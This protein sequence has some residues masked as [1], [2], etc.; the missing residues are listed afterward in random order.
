VIV[1]QLLEQ[2]ILKPI[3]NSIDELTLKFNQFSS[4]FDFEPKEWPL[5]INFTGWL[6]PQQK[7]VCWLDKLKP[8]FESVWRKVGIFEAIITTKCRILKKSKL[9]TRYCGDMVL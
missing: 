7:W 3:A 1:N 2:F 6:L 8:K 4:S 5:K 9:A